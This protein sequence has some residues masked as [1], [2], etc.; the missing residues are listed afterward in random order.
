MIT[1]ITECTNKKI[2]VFRDKYG[3]KLEADDKITHIKP[4]TPNEIWAFLGLMYMRG[5]MKLNLR[6]IH[7]VF[8]HKSSNDS[9]RATMSRKRFSL[10]CHPI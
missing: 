2:D 5:A 4:T 3:E 8:Y 9:F 7:D 1:N 6:N 10:C